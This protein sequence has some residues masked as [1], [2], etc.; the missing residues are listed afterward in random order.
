MQNTKK[1][2]IFVSHP[3]DL[4]TDCQPHG[5]GLVAFGF[6]QHLAQR[7]H[8]LHVV[9]NSVEIR[10]FLPDNIK[11]H[12]TNMESI[13]APFK[14]IFYIIRVRQIFD[15]VQRQSPVDVIHQLNPVVAGLSLSFVGTQCPVILGPIVAHWSIK[16]KL[17]LL[18]T[19]FN[20]IKKLVGGSLFWLQQRQASALLVATPAALTRLHNPN[21]I[22]E[23]IYDLRHGIN[24]RLFAPP[25][26][27]TSNPSAPPSILFLGQVSY[28]K[29]IFTLF[30]AFETVASILPSCQLI[31]AG[32]WDHQIDEIKSRIEKMSGKAQIKL[33]GTVQRVDVPSL[34]NNC[35]V[36]CMPSY[37]E[38][39]GMGALEAMA[40]GKP[41]VGTEAG[42]LQY[43]ISDEGGRKVPPEDP[44][45]LA[46][47]L[48]EILSSS[49]LQREMGQHN[50]N[51]VEKVY[52]W[53]QVTQQLESIYYELVEQKSKDCGQK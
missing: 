22:A 27:R 6:I 49:E 31:V 46:T 28:H 3:S 29:G 34:M 26:D 21:A 1:L 30:E 18:N 37:G 32:S 9:V 48:L 12:P 35:S 7:G 20:Q 17:P 43:L 41:V 14:R 4:L 2:S 50:R 52:D 38:P 5:D 47:A 33:I 40:C 36:Y 19:L 10:G 24:A 53:D 11:I 25:A 42:G 8:T 44:Q 13:P 15:Q 51:L 23:K 45:A 39:F 16:T